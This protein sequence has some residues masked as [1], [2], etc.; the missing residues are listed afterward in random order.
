MRA[1]LAGLLVLGLG[2]VAA[3]PSASPPAPQAPGLVLSGGGARGL[4]HIG[5]LKVLER[6]RIAVSVI[7]GTSM[8]A[9]VGG[10]YASGL[11]ATELE[12]ELLRLDWADV[13][14]SRVERPQLPQRRKDEDYDFSPIVEFGARDGELR[15]PQGTVSSRGLEVLLRR[16]LLPV[17]ELRHFDR[18]PTPFRAVATDMESGQAVIM[19]D[20]D[21]PEALRASMSV[22]GLFTPI[23]RQG[24]LLGDGGLV[25]NLPV[26][27]ARALGA[28]QLIAVNVGTPLAGRQSLQTLVGLTTQM[29]NILTE[30]NVQRSLATLWP[31]DLLLTPQLDTLSSGDF[32]RAADFIR[33]GEA[34]AEQALPVLRGFALSP[35][36]YAQW[37]AARRL[38]AP[39][40]PWLAALRFEGSEHTRPERYLPLLASQVGEAFDTAKAVD[41]VRRL[42]ASGDYER[43]DFRLQRGDEGDTLVFELSDKSWGPNY[44][45][46]GLDLVASGSS[47]SHFNLRI[48]HN[49]HWLNRLGGEWRNQLTIGHQPRL[50]SEIYQPLAQQAGTRRDWFAAG[51]GEAMARRQSLYDDDGRLVA[52]LERRS[53][54]TG[55][56]LGQPWGRYGELRLGWWQQLWNWDENLAI[57]D[58]RLR[59]QLRSTQRIL[60]LRASAEV[61]QLDD[62]NFPRRGWRGEVSALFGRQRGQDGDV[63]RLELQATRADSWGAHTL[64]L[65]LRAAASR[66]GAAL[67]GG[68][69]TLGGFHQLSGLENDQLSGN[70]LLLVRA[71]WAMR[72]GRAPVFTRDWFVGASLEAGNTW[73]A[74]GDL[75]LK[76]LRQSG[77]VFLGADTGLGP[78][79]VGLGREKRGGT[80]LYL[81]IGRP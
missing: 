77:S 48:S 32:A 62:A 51:W 16:L 31:E 33:A 69:Y 45:R 59:R 28:Q 22:P 53:L 36:A 13:F 37:Q 11:T 71:S 57:V 23:E 68:A 52:T 10:L 81:F 74:A 39:P 6:E 21:L 7:T 72:L 49:R 2:G 44:F 27:V 25:N 61:D 20:G 29:V 80:L 30:Q 19:A 66:Q 70:A 79:Y 60:G 18:L 47:D 26:D 41:D 54:T 4:A 56:D 8:G 15:L 63:R 58:D 34:A 3:A 55:L 43:V 40:L 12:R 46:V 50:F 38:Q 5:V 65:H 75:G 17:R 24:R 42:A 14:A 67:L 9:I 64:G 35:E 78:L 1:L 76:G 73:N